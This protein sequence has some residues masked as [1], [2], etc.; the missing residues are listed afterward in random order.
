MKAGQQGLLFSAD[1][2]QKAMVGNERSEK[3]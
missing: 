1:S 3:Q 2:E